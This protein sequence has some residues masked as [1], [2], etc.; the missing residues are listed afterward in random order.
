MKK[1][2]YCKEEIQEEAIK[3]RFCFSN[4]SEPPSGRPPHGDP[5][6]RKPLYPLR[7]A[8]VAMSLPEPEQSIEA[9]TKTSVKQSQKKD[10]K[11]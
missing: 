9:V 4:I 1:C 3:C 8:E 2:S 10:K 5:I 11:L 6:P 7:S